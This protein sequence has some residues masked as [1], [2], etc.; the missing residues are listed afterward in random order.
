MG[1]LDLVQLL[2]EKLMVE[3]PPVGLTF[4][5]E[6]PEDVPLLHRDPES[7]CTLWRWAEERVFYASGPQHVGCGLGGLV[8]GFLDPEGREEELASLLDEMCEGGEGTPEEIA[9]TSRFQRSASGVVYGPL[10]MMPGQP[11][12]ALMWATLPQM[13]VLQEMVG[14]IMW[15]NNPQGAV[16]PRP[17]CSVLPIAATNDNPALSLGCVGMRVYTNVPPD[18]YLIALPGGRLEPL[19]QAITEGE[20]IAERLNFYQQRMAGAG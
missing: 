10:W 8:S 16:F 17:A 5:S 4:A 20:G 9:G 3:I 19:E 14:S 6:P 13:G 7:F 1:F 11:D 15:K 18:L 12:L 2:G